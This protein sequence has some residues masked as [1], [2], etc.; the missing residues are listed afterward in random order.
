MRD[1]LKIHYTCFREIITLVAIAIYTKLWIRIW[2]Q[3]LSMPKVAVSLCQ[4]LITQ[5]VLESGRLK[6]L[7]TN[8][9]FIGGWD[10]PQKDLIL[11]YFYSEISWVIY[12]ISGEPTWPSYKNIYDLWLGILTVFKIFDLFL[13]KRGHDH[14]RVSWHSYHLMPQDTK[15]KNILYIWFRAGIST[16]FKTLRHFLFDGV[17]TFPGPMTYISVDAPWHKEQEHRYG[18]KY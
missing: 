1:I 8:E 14:P 12:C 7:Q 11:D 9:A 18:W 13:F 16:I 5:G 4:E 6:S 2:R 17:R 3:N 15:N 10:D